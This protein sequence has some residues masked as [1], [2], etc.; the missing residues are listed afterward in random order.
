MLGSLLI[1]FFL[2]N[3]LHFP[4]SLFNDFSIVFLNIVLLY[5]GYSGFCSSEEVYLEAG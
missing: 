1:V 3:G 4:I 2:E 5:Y